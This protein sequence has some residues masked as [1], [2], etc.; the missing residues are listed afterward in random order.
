VSPGR[1]LLIDKPV[2]PTSHD[3]VSAVRRALGT[4]RAGHCG[5]LDPAASGLLL[6]LVGE[7]TRLAEVFVG[8]EKV[9]RGR[10]RF[11]VATDTDD[12][13]GQVIARVD[14][15]DFTIEAAALDAALAT[16]AARRSQRPPG[17]SAIK[18][19]GVPLYKLAR[20]GRLDAA[21]LPERPVRVGPIA[22]LAFDGREL[23]LEITCSA[24]TYI[25][26]LARDLGE[27]VGVPAHLAGLR[28]LASGP[29]R[30]EQALPLDALREGPAAAPGLALEEAL[31]SLP[32]V[33]ASASYAERIRFGAQPAPGDLSW[34]EPLP[35][36]GAWLRILSPAAALL[37]LAQVE[38]AGGA[39]RLTLRRPLGDG[40]CASSA[41]SPT[42]PPRGAPWP[43]A[44][45]TACTPATGASSARC[46]TRRRAAASMPRS[47]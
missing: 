10:V 13:Q 4:K 9:Y 40:G 2:G 47:P 8:H 39:P 12:A 17:F 7:A 34:E 32:A 24:G 36:P 22:L 38:S 11:G 20:A 14:D 35:G 41:V 44:S 19:A 27:L 5:T 3:A 18:Q 23:E 45:S 16:L 33:A 42:C 46:S 15:D 6:V 28:R 29:F 1:L 31:A 21:A 43:W 25:R 37:G 30:V 26:A